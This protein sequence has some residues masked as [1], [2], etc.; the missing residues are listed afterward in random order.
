MHS[1]TGNYPYCE[2]E[3]FTGESRRVTMIPETVRIPDLVSEGQVVA[4][5]T[6]D[7]LCEYYLMK[8]THPL[9][10]STKVTKGQWGAVIPQNTEVFT[11]LYYD[12][13]GENRYSLIRSPYAI[14][15]AASILYICAQIDSSKDTIKVSEYLHTSILECVNMSKD[16]R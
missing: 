16:A 12:K 9:S 4:L 5:F 6:D 3:H 14:V 15:P 13:V 10:S 2:N 8:V 11:G 7:E 1:I